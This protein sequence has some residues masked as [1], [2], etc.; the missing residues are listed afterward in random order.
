MPLQLCVPIGQTPS[1]AFVFGM[2]APAHNF[3]LLGQ[4]G[5]HASPSHVTVPPP[6]GAVHA[7]HDVL[8]FGPQVATALLSTHLPPQR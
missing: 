4:A 3:M 5:T 8:S 1:Q 7:V 2:H 6:V